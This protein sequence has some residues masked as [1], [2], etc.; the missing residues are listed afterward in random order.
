MQV[1]QLQNL[2]V[3]RID[4]SVMVVN[5]EVTVFG[6]HTT[7]FVP[8]QTAEYY[9]NGVWH[10]IQMT[11][12]HDMGL[13]TIAPTGEVLLAG[14]MEKEL[15]IGQ[16]FTVE[17][18]NPATH[19][20]KG[21]GCLEEKRCF[22]NALPMDSGNIVVS[23]NWYHDDCIEVY[24]G[25]RQCKFVKPV[26]QHRSQP[27]II[28]T[29]KD[30]AIVFGS[31]DIHADDFDTII[32]DRLKGGPF[33]V[34]LFETWRP[35]C[36]LA[37]SHGSCFIGDETKGDYTSLIQVMRGDSLMAI[38]RVTGE[39]F[40]L[41]PTISP[42]PMRSQWSRI[43]WYAP[44][45]ADRSRG[46]AYIVG[47][48]EN[49]PEDTGDHRFYV[50]AI[51]YLSD[52]SPVTL[53]YSE[54][55]DGAGRWYPV[56]TESGDLMVVGGILQ[57]NN[58]YDPAATAFLLHVG[59]EASVSAEGRQPLWL[60]LVLASL[61]LAAAVVTY[62]L[63]RRHRKS[64]P[65]NEAAQPNDQTTNFPNDQL[66]E[67]ML[68]KAS[69]KRTMPV[70][71]RLDSFGDAPSATGFRLT[72]CCGT[73]QVAVSLE[74]PHQPART[75]QQQVIATEL[76]KLGGT[77]FHCMRVDLPAAFHFFV[78]ASLLS[79]LRRQAV[80]A[81]LQAS[82]TNSLQ[83]S[84]PPSGNDHATASTPEAYTHGYLYNV[85]NHLAQQFYQSQGIATDSAFE[86]HTP[87][88]PLLMQCRYCLRHELGACTRQQNRNAAWR[89]PLYLQLDD[90][91]RF[92][93][94]FDCARCQMNIYADE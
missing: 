91:R 85:A 58:N 47:Y 42:I 74:A 12:P 69:A 22:A 50:A 21:Y 48:G 40:S 55:Q 92:R 15:G 1:E 53:Y 59:T 86:T 70:T 64:L 61:L 83:Q 46:R 84:V 57:Q 44:V 66:M 90:G 4:H 36:P 19:S 77:P 41:L 3:P 81:L 35:I 76:S 71:M 27:H 17:L 89:D 28:R 7:G 2:N 68:S 25:S 16:T 24:D 72:A 79:A 82:R 49:Y 10:L 73:H 14:G 65:A 80:A 67:R 52:P 43:C 63:L 62:I 31:R 88:H 45:I 20:S 33:T 32:V 34:S 11:Y 37:G 6:G 26:A 78:P 93:L 94:H 13:V 5:G 29:A 8:T 87:A 9:R 23:G 18:Y 54:P 30:N 38:A 39:D 51:D 75:P 56:L 60:W